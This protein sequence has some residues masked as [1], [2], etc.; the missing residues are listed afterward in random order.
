[1]TSLME[2]LSSSL[3][4]GVNKHESSSKQF[5][6]TPVKYKYYIYWHY[7][8]YG[9]FHICI[10]ISVVS[11]GLVYEGFHTFVLFCAFS[12]VSPVNE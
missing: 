9:H 10:I 2:I 7:V 12:N 1:M 8:G 5:N 6:D 4:L 3:C 11:R